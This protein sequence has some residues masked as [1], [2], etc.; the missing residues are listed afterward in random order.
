MFEKFVGRTPEYVGENK[1]NSYAVLLPF[2]KEK[3]AFLFEVR[4]ATLAHQPG[5]VCLPGGK[6]EQGE[7]P[8]HAA[9]RETCE[10]LLLLKEK[11]V[12]IIAPLDVQFT[13]WQSTIFPFLGELQYEEGYNESEVQEVFTVPVSFF[14]STKPQMLELTS[15]RI[16]KDPQNFYR[17]L[18]IES[19][20]WESMQETVPVYH[21]EG[22]IIWGLTARIMQNFS[23]LYIDN[24]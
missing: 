4:A 24:K 19:Y 15:S 17:A 14:T 5:E 23:Q 13:P 12:R 3:E 1:N 10:E 9:V 20:T 11:H 6:I 2:I 7:T 22:K 21:Y 8:Q 16:P 18:G